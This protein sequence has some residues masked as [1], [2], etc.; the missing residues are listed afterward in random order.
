ID[1][2]ELETGRRLTIEDLTYGERIRRTKDVLLAI[3]R[4]E[5]LQDNAG[6]VLVGEVSRQHAEPIEDTRGVTIQLERHQRILCLDA[7]AKARVVLIQH[8]ARDAPKQLFP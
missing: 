7:I 3:L 5:G 4:R 2:T 1:G 8:S 6:A